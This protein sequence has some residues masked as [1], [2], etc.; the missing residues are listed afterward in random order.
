MFDP[1]LNP[2]ASPLSDAKAFDPPPVKSNAE[3]IRREHI[4]HETS[5]K[6]VGLLYLLSAILL[7]PMG[8]LSS[9]YGFRVALEGGADATGATLV[10][11]VGFFYMG[12]GALSA[13]M[14]RGFRNLQP[15]IKIP[16]TVLGALGLLSIPI[17]TIINGYILYLMHCE[18]GKTVFS[19]NYKLIIA[20]TPHVKYRTS[21][22][23]MALA[24]LLVLALVSICIAG[25]VLS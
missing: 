9:L 25:A 18:K 7:I 23:V 22:I 17:G 11:G 6:A 8:V 15:W 5:V 19:E 14:W 12:F 13:A 21:P 24:I 10:G 2:Y 20:Q 3:T 4:A 1:N 16:A